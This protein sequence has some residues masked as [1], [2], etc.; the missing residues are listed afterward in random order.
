MNKVLRIV[1]SLIGIFL[2]IGFINVREIHAQGATNVI[3]I[4][5]TSKSMILG[6]VFEQVKNALKEY[7][8]A[9]NIN[10]RI[11]ILAFDEDV[12]IVVDTPITS[13][14]EIKRIQK[15]I[16]GLRA[17]GDWTYMTQALDFAA[18]QVKRLQAASPQNTQLIYLLT[19]GKN[20]P[21]PYLKEP[22]LQF[23]DVLTRHFET[24][25]TEGTYVYILSLRRPDPQLIDFG[26]KI[27]A[28]ISEEPISIEEPLPPTVE[29]QLS[30]STLGKVDLS[31]R[32]ERR[33]VEIIVKN[34]YK[35]EGKEIHLAP[36]VEDAPSE[37]VVE[38]HPETI[39]CRNQGQREKILLTLSG[40]TEYKEYVGFLNITSPE[41]NVKIIPSKLDFSFTV[42][43]PGIGIGRI[44]LF[45]LILI[46]LIGILKIIYDSLRPPSVLW[47]TVDDREPVKVRLQGRRKVY[48]GER[49]SGFFLS[50]NLPR[51]SLKLGGK[52][53]IFLC[54][55]ES[56]EKREINFSDSF[57]CQDSDGKTVTLKFYKENPI[58]PS[59]QEE[60]EKT[61]KGPMWG[62]ISQE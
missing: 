28:P 37:L 48:L 29:L 31:K 9:R 34:M 6:G 32:K 7:V 44:L 1:S 62:D 13:Q 60:E 24:L 39:V 22:P 51:Y 30:K 52:D 35:F 53:K 46:A 54:E 40:S 45:I 11:L 14:E 26:R 27:K 25:T 10:D 58:E 47:A 55:D 15:I 21:P 17:T 5:D 50:F 33:S 61:K 42:K 41:S 2:F 12:R 59:I 19:D 56:S 23:I 3:F 43:K 18:K 57:P 38:V 4:L 20:D 36:S 49:L 16:D 8:N